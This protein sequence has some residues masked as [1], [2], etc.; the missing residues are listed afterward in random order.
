[1]RIH[2]LTAT[3]ALLVLLLG[4]LL[5]AAPH[6]VAAQEGAC[7]AETGF[8]VQ[9]RFL[10]YWQE[11]GGL[12]IN[13]FPL[14]D[15]RQELLEDGNTYTVQYFE[16]VRLEYHPENPA[17]YDVLLGQFGRRVVR[18]GYGQGAAGAPVQPAQP[19][20][21]A[22]Y[23][24]ETGHNLAEPFLT[25]W[26]ANGGL[27]Q[28][29]YPITE[30]FETTL[31]D[32]QRYRVQYFERARFELHPENAPPYDVLL[33]QFGRQILAENA[34]LAGDP[35]F[36]RLYLTDARVR[37][38]VGSPTG[39]VGRTSGAFQTFERGA[40]IFIGN[41]GGRGAIYA[42]CGG[43]EMGEV[44]RPEKG[45]R[46]GSPPDPFEDTWQP[47]DDPGGGMGP[48]PGLYLPRFGFGKL[49]REN[50]RVRDCL[51]YATQPEEATYTLRA[52]DFSTFGAR[53][54]SAT[55]PEGRFIYVFYVLYAPSAYIYERYP[56]PAP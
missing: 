47:G 14:G 16:R 25:Y 20:A 34:L 42:L 43:A 54:L 30:I 8:C 40:M 2:R 55:T 27:A 11:H 36:A 33:G 41:P 21:G 45:T 28:F 49:W 19:I 52:Q 51:G 18:R 23:F 4:G 12:A 3:L 50:Q 29:G 39:P 32:G 22:A 35:G 31:E 13:G 24:P 56:D 17:P 1:M 9:G 46:G 15:E 48:T 6:S 37:D 5:T 26:Q 53:L 7:F 10:A 44:L 38:L